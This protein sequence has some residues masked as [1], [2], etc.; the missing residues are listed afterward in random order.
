M[1]YSAR[2]VLE[3]DDHGLR[4]G[5]PKAQPI[6]T[7][8][9][10]WPHTVDDSDALTAARLV[11]GHVAGPGNHLGI[12]ADVLRVLATVI[13]RKSFLVSLAA[14]AFCV[15]FHNS[16]FALLGM[17][18]I[19]GTSLE[20]TPPPSRVSSTTV[21]RATRSRDTKTYTKAPGPCRSRGEMEG[22]LC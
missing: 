8:A 7:T 18:T 4:T 15:R 9:Q 3:H 19:P 17:M 6:A 22:W 1:N 12:V 10:G 5:S 2:F 16:Y 13:T 11:T 21:S 14:S 20:Y